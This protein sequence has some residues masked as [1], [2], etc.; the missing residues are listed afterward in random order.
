MGK[1]SKLL[2]VAST[3]IVILF[4]SG[5]A[6]EPEPVVIPSKTASS[7]SPKPTTSVSTPQSTPSSDLPVPLA[8]EPMDKSCEKIFPV[9]RLYNFNANIGLIPNQA[10]T[11][12]PSAQKQLEL[13]GIS[14]VLTN[15]SSGATTEVVLTKLTP[16]SAES[17]SKELESLFSQGNYQVEN[18]ITASFS[19]HSGQFVKNNYWVSISSTDFANPIDA[20]RVS[21]LVAQG[22]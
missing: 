8:S 4:S 17:K 22:L 19:N 21:N 3:G 18:G 1:T 14:C 20:S 9:D 7:V 12:A 11:I 16:Q 2:L 15:L 13:G 5:C 10:P 6:P